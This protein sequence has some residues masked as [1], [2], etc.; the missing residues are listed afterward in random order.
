MNAI[1]HCAGPF[2]TPPLLHP[3][4]VALEEGLDYADLGDDPTYL[5]KTNEF[6]ATASHEGRLA[7]CG[8]SSLPSMTSLLVAL[9]TWKF[10]PIEKIDIHVFIGNRNPKGW[11]RFNISSMS[12]AIRSLQCEG[13]NKN[14][15]GLGLGFITSRITLSPQPFL[16]AESNPLMI[17]FSQ[18]GLKQRMFTFG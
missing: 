12:C 16:L 8:A 10:G 1:F 6:F 14:L 18:N 3:L 5:N 15:N 11:V 9:G 7:I 4:S 2:S 17:I 13:E